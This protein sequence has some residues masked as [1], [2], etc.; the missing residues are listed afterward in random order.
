MNFPKRIE[1]HKHESDSFATIL[2][3]LK[4]IGIF[5]NITESDYGIDFEIEVVN[6]NQ[7]EGHCIKVQVK[8]SDK[9]TVRKRDGHARV[10]G[11]KQSTLYYWAELSYNVPIVAIA[12]DLTEG[13]IY[14]SDNLFWQAVSLIDATE[15]DK[16]PKSKSIDFGKWREIQ[17]EIK[18][19]KRIAYG[20]GL[21][22]EL[23]AHKWMLRNLISV[24]ALYE[25]SVHCH[26]G[27]ST[28]ED[29]VFR[30]F[31]E[32]ARI[33]LGIKSYPEDEDIKSLEK[34][35]DY[36]FIKNTT[37]SGEIG[38]DVARKVMVCIFE[39]LLPRLRLYQV[40]VFNS[41]YYWAYK[42][43]DYLKL[44]ISTDIPKENDE[45][46]LCEYGRRNPFDETLEREQTFT[47]VIDE[48]EKRY[49]LPPNELFFKLSSL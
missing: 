30:S 4:E 25:N 26:N 20:Y 21:R 48:I 27:Y 22:D 45:K 28:E 3:K 15:K 36:S 24:L 18:R 6:G 19:L 17:D 7:V 12:V 35:F 34:L 43:P 33:L 8:S 23:N 44:V 49:N 5:R 13:K 41:A 1:Q 47:K 39:I 9:L 32:S 40:K 2:Y 14:I 16:R 38:Y 31:L 46:E 37:K 29:I 10:G 42:D 11:I